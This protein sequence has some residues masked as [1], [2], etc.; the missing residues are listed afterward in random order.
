MEQAGCTEKAAKSGG[1]ARRGGLTFQRV[2][3][4]WVGISGNPGR[5][6]DPNFREASRTENLIAKVLFNLD[7]HP[8]TIENTIDLWC[9]LNNIW[10]VASDV[11]STAVGRPT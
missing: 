2:I 6:P 3:A 1:Y 10:I 9:A 8:G 7:D 4:F 11:L 5:F